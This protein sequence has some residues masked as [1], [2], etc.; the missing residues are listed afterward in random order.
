MPLQPHGSLLTF[1]RFTNR[2]IIIIIIIIS[3]FIKIQNV[4]TFLFLVPAYPGCHGKEA[5]KLVSVCIAYTNQPIFICNMTTESRVYS[6]KRILSSKILTRD[7]TDD[8]VTYLQF[9]IQVCFSVDRAFVVSSRNAQ[10]AFPPVN[11]LYD[12]EL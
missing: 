12:L 5:F 1:W 3:C 4:L 6:R 11:F 10:R 9:P 2:I 8:F 7:R